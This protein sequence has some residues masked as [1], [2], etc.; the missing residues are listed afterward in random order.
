[1][2]NRWR[3]SFNSLPLGSSFSPF[4]VTSTSVQF[5]MQNIHTANIKLEYII[6]TRAENCVFDSLYKVRSILI[7]R[8][9]VA[10]F[11]IHFR[12]VF[13]SFHPFS[14]EPP[15]VLL[16]KKNGVKFQFIIYIYFGILYRCGCVCDIAYESKVI[17]H[18][19][20]YTQIYCALDSAN[21]SGKKIRTVGTGAY[22]FNQSK[23]SRS[24]FSRL[25]AL[26]STSARIDPAEKAQLIWLNLDSNVLSVLC[27]YMPTEIV[28]NS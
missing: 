26:K 21:A 8:R 16:S 20:K 11:C 7:H 27:G 25:N 3:C 24:E 28:R 9:L 4:I 18:K 6:T 14:T 2:R 13:H 1:M 10:F 19:Y 5:T 15:L 17:W 23:Y 22:Y 12:F